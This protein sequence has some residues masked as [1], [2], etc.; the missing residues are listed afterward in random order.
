M[1][2]ERA[3]WGKGYGAEAV[4][5]VSRWL[6]EAERLDRVDAGSGNPA[7]LRLVEKLGWKVEVIKKAHV[8]IGGR[9]VDW[10]QVALQSDNFRRIPEFDCRQEEQ[11][12]SA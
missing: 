3:A 2:G 1:I 9:A 5:L 6:F 4:Y 10:T 11:F 12:V 8:Q 7:F